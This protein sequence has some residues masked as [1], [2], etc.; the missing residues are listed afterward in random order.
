M[1]WSFFYFIEDLLF[2]HFWGG[3]EEYFSLRSI[4]SG[5]FVLFLYFSLNIETYFNKYKDFH[6]FSYCLR[7]SQ[8]SLS[9]NLWNPPSVLYFFFFPGVYGQVQIYSAYPKM[10]WTHLGTNVAPG[11]E[12]W[13]FAQ[14]CFQILNFGSCSYDLYLIF[15]WVALSFSFLIGFVWILSREKKQ[16]R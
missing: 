16:P 1:W 7:S 8:A 13:Y 6:I 14:I 3:V 5:G 15:L 12:R 4:L 9:L 11:N 2:L 10:P